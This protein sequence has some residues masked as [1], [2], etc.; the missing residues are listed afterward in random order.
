MMM[1]LLTQL[2]KDVRYLKYMTSKVFKACKD[3][4]ILMPISIMVYKIH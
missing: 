3:I 1:K 2:F 4:E